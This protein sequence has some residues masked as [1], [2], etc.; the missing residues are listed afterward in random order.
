MQQAVCEGN[1]RLAHVKVALESIVAK[2]GLDLRTR[3][4]IR[5]IVTSV[6]GNKGD[7]P[8][9]E[10]V[11]GGP[12]RAVLELQAAV[13]QRD[14][15]LRCLETQLREARS[16][17]QR[18]EEIFATRAREL[19]ECKDALRRKD[20]ENSDLRANLVRAEARADAT[21]QVLKSAKS[22]LSTDNTENQDPLDL[23]SK[24]RASCLR[25]ESKAKRDLDREQSNLKELELKQKHLQKL[26]AEI[27]TK[28]ACIASLAASEREATKAVSQYQKRITL[29]EREAEQLRS[30][31]SPA[32]ASKKKN[33]L[34]R[35]KMQDVERVEQLRK[36]SEV[37]ICELHEEVSTL[38][39]QRDSQAKSRPVTA[40]TRDKLE[41]RAHRWLRRRL[42]AVT[43]PPTAGAAS[44]GDPF[45]ALRADVAELPQ[46]HCAAALTEAL[47]QLVSHRINRVVTP[48][49]P[50]ATIAAYEAKIDMLLRELHKYE[51]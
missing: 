30:L 37:R 13:D 40:R 8:L 14:A 9:G 12:V 20:R 32:T 6:G 28:E 48:P 31:Q 15:K 23:T 4:A 27:S 49:V 34:A 5:E 33:E 45:D 10:L 36:A 1:R 35:L 3:D 26:E 22:R 38:K 2:G 11:T 19:R 47:R 21:E 44:S 39:S 7:P 43:R 41:K 25:A 18:D 46:K 29:L 42:D 24:L 51:S 17:L 16:D 50:P